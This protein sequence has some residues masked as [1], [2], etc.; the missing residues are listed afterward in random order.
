MAL[1]CYKCPK[2]EHIDELMRPMSE[3]DEPHECSQCGATTQRVMYPGCI[4]DIPGF[5][6][7]QNVTID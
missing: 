6:N 4:F 5:R 7:G 2:C 3:A 1:Y